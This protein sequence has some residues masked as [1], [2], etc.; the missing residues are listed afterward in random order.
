MQ[1]PSIY[2]LTLRDMM[3]FQTLTVPNPTNSV[4]EVK[5]SQHSVIKSIIIII[6]III[7]FRCWKHPAYI[8]M[9]GINTNG[10]QSQI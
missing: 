9:P 1:I 7:Q 8:C 2:L 4:R 10:L 6:I 5:V 3:N